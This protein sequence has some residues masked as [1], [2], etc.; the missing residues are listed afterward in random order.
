MGIH[1]AGKNTPFLLF[2]HLCIVVLPRGTKTWRI[3][4]TST[5][6]VS[7]F[8]MVVVLLKMC[9]TNCCCILLIF[10]VICSL[11][12][13]P[14]QARGVVDAVCALHDANRGEVITTEVK[15]VSCISH[16]VSWSRKQ[17]TPLPVFVV[18]YHHQTFLSPRLHDGVSF[19]SATL[20][21][22]ST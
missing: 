14:L 8:Q 3:L 13:L 20:R 10:V 12:P 16:S 17:L 15:P 6:E 4:P 11:S 5:Y 1:R 22:K 18:Y 2:S 7:C 19:C 21:P 9:V